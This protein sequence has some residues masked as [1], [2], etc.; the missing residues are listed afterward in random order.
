LNPKDTV[1]LSR[2]GKQEAALCVFCGG[3]AAVDPD[4]GV[5]RSL[6]TCVS[7]GTPV[8][9]PAAGGTAG[10]ERTATCA[11]CGEAKSRPELSGAPDEDV[12]ARLVKEALASLTPLGDAETAAYF[13]AVL[14]ALASSAGCDRSAFRL[15]PVVELGFRSASLPGGAILTGG[16]LLCAL[17]DEAMLAFVVAR[18]LAHQHSGRVYRRYRSRR[19]HGPLGASLGWGLGLLTAGAL[20]WAAGAADQLLEVAALGYGTVHELDAD[21]WAMRTIEAAGFDP[22]GAV[23][24]LGLIE[25]RQVDGR[26]VLAGFLEVPPARSRRRCLLE[27]LLGLGRG[28]ADARGRINRE[29]Y[30]RITTLLAQ[31]ALAVEAES[32]AARNEPR[33]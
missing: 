4:S 5:A 15:H 23:R 12:S 27:T 20:P 1:L 16:E 9:P 14:G 32:P 31:M 26:G 6:D 19:A 30:R 28:E 21:E 3:I 7:C 24:Y 2:S 18:E 8:E 13:A 11:P 10:V 29:G 25:K 22:A 17:E 33:A